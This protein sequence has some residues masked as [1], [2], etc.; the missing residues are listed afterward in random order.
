MTTIAD[1]KNPPFVG[2]ACIACPLEVRDLAAT[3]HNLLGA[4]ERSEWDR[5]ASKALGLR[6]ALQRIQ[7]HI[8]AHFSDPAHSHGQVRKP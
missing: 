7:P 4:I 3:A 2:D 1:V 6:D 8:D 5:V